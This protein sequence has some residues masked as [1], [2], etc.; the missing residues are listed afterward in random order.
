L[1]VELLIGV[2]DLQPQVLAEV[3]AHRRLEDQRFAGAGGGGI[4]LVAVDRVHLEVEPGGRLR[5]DEGEDVVVV[6]GLAVVVELADP[7]AAVEE[8][9]AR[10]LTRG[11][12]FAAPI[13]TV[14]S[15]VLDVAQLAPQPEAL[16]A[17]VAIEAAFGV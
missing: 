3:E 13:E 16:P 5:L 6:E 9:L 1:H 2:V 14:A 11:P 7:E 8:E 12:E 4:G 17:A 10:V 15:V